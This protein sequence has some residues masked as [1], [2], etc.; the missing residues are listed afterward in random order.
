[1]ALTPAG[2]GKAV[3]ASAR[4][5]L[6]LLG[7]CVMS[8]KWYCRGAEGQRKSRGQIRGGAGEVSSA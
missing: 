5:M 4:A 1:M 2:P 8:M 3:A 7:Y 6:I